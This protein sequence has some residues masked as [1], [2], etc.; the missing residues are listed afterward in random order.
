MNFLNWGEGEGWVGKIGEFWQRSV[1]GDGYWSE[2]LND[3]QIVGGNTVHF[4]HV[5]FQCT[6]E[7]GIIVHN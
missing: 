7:S 2:F 3:G 6:G 1:E 4:D 5:C